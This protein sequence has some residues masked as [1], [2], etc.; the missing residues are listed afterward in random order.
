L[1]HLNWQGSVYHGLPALY[2]FYPK[3]GSYLAFLGRIA[4]E[5]RPDHAIEIAR[6]VG[7]PLRMAAKVDDANREYFQTVIAP[8]LKDPLVE[9]IGE[10]SDAEKSLFL[11]NAAAVLCPYDW[12]E[13]FGL[14]L[15]EALACGTPVFA[16]QRGS[17]PE[18]IEDGITGFICENLDEMVSAMSR[19]PRIQRQHC[20]QAFEARFAVTRM[21][22]DYVALYEKILNNRYKPFINRR[23]ARKLNRCQFANIH[24]ESLQ[25]DAA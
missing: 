11:G 17:I 13:P 21:V 1:P 14:V 9:Y 20:R 19:L 2:P 7:M 5:K 22:K 4:P 16:Y 12:P 3:P 6:R 25:G 10:I 8:L 18:I 23:V 24:T 15:I